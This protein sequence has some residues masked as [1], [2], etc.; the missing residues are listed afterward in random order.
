VTHTTAQY[1]VLLLE[2]LD[3]AAET[4]LGASAEVLRARS[5]EPAGSIDTAR[6]GP[7]HAIITRGK[8]RVTPELLDACE[9]LRAVAR[10]GVGLDNVD[11]HAATARGIPVL[12]L[13]GSNAATVAE[14]TLMLILAVSRGLVEYANAVRAG[15]WDRRA[16]Y[17]RDEANGR[18][19]GIVGLGN[20][21]R[22]VAAMC[23]ACGM[24]VVYTDPVAADASRERVQLDDLLCR[25][26]VVTLHCQLDAS[27]RALLTSERLALMKPGAILINTARGELVD[28]PAIIDAITAGRLAGYG[29]DLVNREKPDELA[30]LRT[31]PNVVITPHV[32][33]LTRSTYRD[34]CLR[35]VRNVLAIL[36]GD[37]PEPGCVFNA[38]D[39]K[40][41]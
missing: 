13:P 22:R 2:T 30:A 9:G 8:G 38:A 16:S 12:N 31:L 3:A 11:V 18:T 36:R 39:L 21:G 32:S 15:D 26:D 23:E 5:T 1:R 25:A 41:R 29:A 17:D 19:V 34:M 6:A 10:A 20:I 14:H 27:T 33:S 28:Q 40:V 24:R 7:V 35:S 4:L 37:A